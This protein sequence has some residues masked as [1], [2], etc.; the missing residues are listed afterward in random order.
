MEFQSRISAIKMRMQDIQS[1]FG[2]SPMGSANAMNP[3]A[4]LQNPGSTAGVTFDKILASKMEGAGNMPAPAASGP[5]PAVSTKAS[6]YDSI[7]NEASTQYGV[8]A[9]F[10]KAIIQQ[11]S[12]FNPNATSG[13]GAMGMMQLMPETAKSLGVNNGYDARENI[14]GGVKYIKQQLDAFGGDKEKALAAYNAGPGN[15]QK[16]GGIPPFAETQNYVKN[17]MSM[18]KGMGGN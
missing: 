2:T 9:R 13:C 17:I 6:D 4:G 16:Y 3:T 5:A 8:D 11:E 14:M 15:V 1:K 18:Y 12:G 10:I 7:I